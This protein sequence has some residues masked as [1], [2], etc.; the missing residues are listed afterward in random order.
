MKNKVVLIARRVVFNSINDE[1]LFFEWLDR[2]PCVSHYE[3]KGRSLSIEV[4]SRSVNEPALR[5]LLALFDRYRI[6]KKQLIALDRKKF[7]KWFRDDRSYWFASVFG[8]QEAKK[9]FQTART[10]APARS[11]RPLD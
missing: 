8:G 2:I 10:P 6:H 7:S 1:A 11:S 3:G 4:D 5:D 9:E